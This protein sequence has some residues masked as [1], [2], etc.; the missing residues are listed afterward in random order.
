M[1]DHEPANGTESSATAGWIAALDANSSVDSF[2]PT[3]DRWSLPGDR[4][5]V[6][7]EIARGG[8][9]VVLRVTDSALDRPLAVKVLLQPARVHVDGERRFLEEA[10]ITGQLQH[11]GIPPIHDVGRLADGRPFFSMKLIEGRTLAD[12]LRE[13][14]TP[15]TDLPRFLKIFEQIAQTLGFAHSRGIIHRDL[16]PLNIMVGAFGEVQVMDWGLAKRLS[17]QGPEIIT[18]SVATDIP[19]DTA[20]EKQETVRYEQNAADSHTRAGD[21]LGTFAY[22]APEQ[23]R[24]EAPTL[25]ERC[26]VFGLGAILCTILTGRPPY[27]SA[28]RNVLWKQARDADLADAFSRLDHCG[29]DADLIRLTR[30][31]LAPRKQDR[32]HNAGEI[33]DAVS[34]HLATVQERLEQVRVARA[35]AEVQAREE[36]K[37]RRLALGLA[38]A[39]LLLVAGASAAG[40]WYVFDQGQRAAETGARREYLEREITAALDEADR[41]QHVL[42]QRLRDERQAAQLLSNLNQWR[43]SSES[44]RAAWRRADRL[45]AG[46]RDMLPPELLKRLQSTDAELRA[47]EQQRQLAIELDRIRL[48][49]TNVVKEQI[50]LWRAAPKMEN[51]FRDAGFDMLQDAPEKTADRIRRSRIRFPLVAGVDF[52]ALLTRDAELRKR[53]LEVARSADPDPWRDR[54]RQVDEWRNIERLNALAAEADYQRQSPQILAALAQRLRLS[55]GDARPLLRR[56]V[57]FHPQDFWLHFELGHADNDSLLQIGAFRAALSIRPDSPYSYYALGVTHYNHGERVE[58][59]DCYRKAIEL[60]DKYAAAHGNLGLVLSDL[61]RLDEALVHYGRAIE[62]DPL[63]VSALINLGSAQQAQNKLLEAVDLYR[64]ALEIDPTNA[65]AHINLGTALRAEGQLDKAIDRFRRAISIAPGNPYAWCNLG[66]TLRQQGKFNE[67]LQALQ[68]GHELG[69]RAKAWTHPSAQWVSETQQLVALDEKLDGFVTGTQQPADAQENLALGALCVTYR[70]RFV[71]ASRF[72]A[73]CFAAE[74]KLT[75]DLQAGHRYNAACAAALASAGKG[76]EAGKLSASDRAGFRKQAFDWLQADL[77]AWTTAVNQD[78]KSVTAAV[79]M[80]QHWQTDADL[81]DV[82]NESN[83]ADFPP[84]EQATWRQFWSSVADRLREWT[85]SK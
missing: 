12:L 1:N 51:A 30:V 33:A 84:E 37:R 77:A 13:R 14:P 60:D 27:D 49:S 20:V 78:S 73:A 55:R 41:Q 50:E 2:H 32:P 83:L 47:D 48:E 43:E 29:A 16:K 71:S 61:G 7:G 25:D 45:A 23:A 76:I 35:K 17:L 8:M 9:G 10:A 19:A 68:R 42:D 28:D 75:A 81:A 4:Y 59:L 6:V 56:A 5:R 24:G 39:V 46:G 63:Q 18:A 64:R 3:D 38:G 69:S 65:A 85:G 57:I 31:C 22:M 36:R 53:L 70:Q 80:L 52:W 72:Y 82:R 21:V 40:L 58:A 66:N 54:F 11:P 26:D 74:P 67:A 15:Q 62:L 79:G 44:I 34:R